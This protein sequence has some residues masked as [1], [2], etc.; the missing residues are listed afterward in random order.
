MCLGVTRFSRKRRYVRSMF[1]FA[2]RFDSR[3]GESPLI[4]GTDVRVVIGS[5]FRASINGARQPYVRLSMLVIL[6]R[7]QSERG[8]R[9]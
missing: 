4:Y 1:E 8:P 2:R 6:T 5:G 3:D 7:D 9:G